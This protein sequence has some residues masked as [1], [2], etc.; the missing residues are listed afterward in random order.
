M[1]ALLL[2]TRASGTAALI[3]ERREPTHGKTGGAEEDF[4]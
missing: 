3:L 2:D 4:G 1:E